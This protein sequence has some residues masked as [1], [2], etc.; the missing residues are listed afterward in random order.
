MFRIVPI[1]PLRHLLL[2]IQV[3]E[4]GRRGG[5]RGRKGNTISYE[6]FYCNLLQH[7]PAVLNYDAVSVAIST[8]A[9]KAEY[10]DGFS[11]LFDRAGLN[12]R[13]DGRHVSES[14]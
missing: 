5:G 9:V 6:E 11:V 10:L 13:Q 14:V 8:A 1:T 4:I 2:E 12:A 7:L 3:C